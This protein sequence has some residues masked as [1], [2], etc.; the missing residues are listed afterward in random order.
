[1][2]ID[3]VAQSHYNNSHEY[4]YQFS[5]VYN[6]ASP[7]GES[8]QSSWS[9][10]VGSDRISPSG[11]GTET[12]NLRMRCCMGTKVSALSSTSND[13]QL[14][15]EIQTPYEVECKIEGTAALL[16]HRWSCDAIEEKAA[17]RKGSAAKKTDNIESYLYRDEKGFLAIPAEYFRQSI[18]HA[19][20]FKQDPRSPRKSAMDLFKAGICTL[21][22]MCSLKVKGPDFLDR[23]R[24]VIQRSGITRVRP[25][26]LAGWKCA[27]NLQVLLPEYIDPT[28]L[29]ET[30]QYAGRI[31]GIGDFRPSFGRFVVTGFNVIE[32][33]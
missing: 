26:M 2:S 15:V 16:F 8:I 24:V 33:K 13:A 29:N 3:N 6:G 1:M 18:I 7:F 21:N 19:A 28:L 31:V 20:K 14:D 23:R 17:A 27:V 32:L 5:I 25:A 12:Q 30:L 4:S 10:K 11:T 22:E 9:S